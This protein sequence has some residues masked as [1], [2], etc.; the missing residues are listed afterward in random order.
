[1]GRV[2]QFS[3]NLDM[4]RKV[5]IDLVE[6]S[7]QGSV[8]SW[9]A[10]FFMSY[11]F[12]KET[13]DFWTMRLSSELVLDQR[14]SNN[15]FIKATFN[16]TMMDLKCDYVQVDVVSVLGNNQN[17]TKFV[18]KT[19]LDGRG[20]LFGLVSDCMTTI[21]NFLLLLTEASYLKSA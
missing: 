21:L 20:V 7:K 1:M 13:I 12:Y 4:Y 2:R 14:Q 19:P 6:G 3:K 5:P 11:L 18:K 16:I 10:I 17:V 8:A 15:D 9:V